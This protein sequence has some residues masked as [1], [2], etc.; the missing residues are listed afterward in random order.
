MCGPYFNLNALRSPEPKASAYH[1]HIYFEPGTAGEQKAI[2]VAQRI[3]ARF[4][5]AVEDAH[6]VGKIGPH[7]E[8]NIGVTIT[9]E[10]FGE[11]VSW[12]QLNSQGLSILVHPRTG[13]ELVDHLDAA[14]WLGKP[15]PFNDKF[16]EQLK[17]KTPK[18]PALQ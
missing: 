13:D 4:P 11:V 15:V 1:I 8:A 7:T 10:S 18:G 5:G 17:P 6:R 14:M 2:D 12:L 16:F 9:P 3:D